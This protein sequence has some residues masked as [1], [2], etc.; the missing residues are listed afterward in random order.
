MN[1]KLACMTTVIAV[2][3]ALPAWAADD[4]KEAKWEEQRQKTDEICDEALKKLFEESE[5]SKE[6]YDKAVGYAVFDNI[7]ISLFISGG[8]GKGVAV[9]KATAQRTYMNMG[10]GGVN[11]GFGGQKF[12]VVFLF[13][14]SSTLTDFVENGWK[15]EA[16]ANAAAGT[17]GANVQ[18]G[19]TNGMATY[20]MT[21]AGLMLQADISGTKYW[22]DKN[23]NQLPPKKDD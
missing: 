7:K 15:A 1:R 3:L 16:G 17:A 2:A 4:K 8:G 19:F 11:L 6:L 12:Q 14:D 23:L 9:D 13:E 5:K 18:T 10:T 22:K 21:E 20:Q